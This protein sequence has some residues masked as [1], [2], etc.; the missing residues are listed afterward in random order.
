MTNSGLPGSEEAKSHLFCAYCGT[1]DEADYG[2]CDHCGEKVE[3]PDDIRYHPTD[4]GQCPECD[5]SN[6]LHARHCVG[7]GVLLDDH[8]LV[9]PTMRADR[10]ISDAAYPDPAVDLPDKT[11]VD[12]L[13]PDITAQKPLSPPKPQKFGSSRSNPPS[14]RDVDTRGPGV[15]Y[16]ALKP[17]SEDKQTDEPDFWSDEQ[18]D[19]EP[20]NSG[21]PEAELP[22]ELQGF[23]WGALILAP[24]WGVD[25]KAW[26]TTPLFAL[27]ILPVPWQIGLP[28]YV[29]VSIFVGFHANELAWKSKKWGS[30]R[31]FKR[32]QQ[33]WA[34]WGFIASPIVMLGIITVPFGI[35]N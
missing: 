24:I 2:Y 4:L 32:I 23:N 27:W 16:R 13:P 35:W 22:P 5:A 28:I 25:N 34:F 14:L 12:D 10:S 15:P 8:P 18:P 3:A 29:V 6:Q 20:N 7:C 19:D 9:P 21:H 31:D 26:V 33:S 1:E 11:T 17:D 30:I